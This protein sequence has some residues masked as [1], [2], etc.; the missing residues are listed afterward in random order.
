MATTVHTIDLH[1]AAELLGAHP[2]TVRLKVKA[3]MIPGCK[4]GKR[5][6]FSM[7]A[8]ERFLAGEWAPQTAPVRPAVS[9]ASP[10]AKP[11]TPEVLARTLSEADRRYREALAPASASKRRS[12]SAG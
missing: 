9:C 3:G 7:T 5:W 8:L 4:V 12:S 2:E 10:S 11:V 1:T 6:M